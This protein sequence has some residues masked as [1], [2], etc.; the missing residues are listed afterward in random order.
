MHAAPSPPRPSK[1]SLESLPNEVL[2]EIFWFCKHAFRVPKKFSLL[3]ALSKVNR[4]FHQLVTPILGSTLHFRRPSQ[5]FAFLR[6][7]Y[8]AST[9]SSNLDTAKF[10]RHLSLGYPFLDSES[11][12]LDLKIVEHPSIFLFENLRTLEI[13]SWMMKNP[14]FTIFLSQHAPR[15]KELSMLVSIDRPFLNLA[16]LR[17]LDTLRITLIPTTRSIE[18]MTIAHDPKGLLRISNITTFCFHDRAGPRATFIFR[19]SVF[20][21]KDTKRDPQ[22]VFQFID[23]HPTLREVNVEYFHFCVDIR[24]EAVVKLAEGTGLWVEPKE[25]LAQRKERGIATP[26]DIYALKTRQ[27]VDPVAEVFLEELFIIEQPDDF[28]NISIDV[29]AFAFKRMLILPGSLQGGTFGPDQQNPRYKVEQLAINIPNH[30]FYDNGVLT[31]I[32]D[33][34]KLPEEFIARIEHLTVLSSTDAT[35]P[36]YSAQAMMKQIS[37]HLGNWKSLRVLSLAH[38]ALEEAWRLPRE[39]EISADEDACNIDDARRR[40]W[41][42]RLSGEVAQYITSL[43]QACPTLE[44][45]HIRV[46]TAGTEWFDG[47]VVRGDDAVWSWKI[48]RATG[49]TQ[50]RKHNVQVHGHLQWREYPTQSSP[51]LEILV[52]QELEYHHRVHLHD[53]P[54][55]HVVNNTK[56]DPCQIFQFIDLHPS[57]REV[58]VGFFT[59]LSVAIRLEAVFKLVEGTGLWADPTENLLER[60]RRGIVTSRDIY[61][62]EK[63]QKMDRVE[64]D[65]IQGLNIAEQP[66]DFPGVMVTVEAFA[67]T[68]TLA[69]P[70]LDPPFIP[71][72]QWTK[73]NVENPENEFQHP[74]F[75]A[76]ELALQIGDQCR[77]DNGRQT[78]IPDIFKLPAHFVAAIE[79]FTVISKTVHPSLDPE[80]GDEDTAPVQ[81]L[82]SVLDDICLY[83]PNWQNLRVLSIHADVLE[84]RDWRFSDPD[85]CLCDNAECQCYE[86]WFGDEQIA[87]IWA[88][89]HNT[90]MASYVA[91]LARAPGKYGTQDAFGIGRFFGIVDLPTVCKLEDY[92]ITEKRLAS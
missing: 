35:P 80:D 78:D 92:S 2:L 45:V 77:Y 60:K 79:K 90:E 44:E 40:L 20:N 32:P 11:L 10:V 87:S 23:L 69:L 26:R 38:P 31:D 76:K 14:D 43:A 9:L 84:N 12:G 37:M 24:L 21:T 46:I 4:R 63:K 39:E 49:E 7:T 36:A 50:M 65:F 13:R 8:D 81:S 61:A 64:V 89:K 22:D 15:L 41:R 34:F 57:L 5:Y 47:H 86:A 59:K 29:I 17:D 58:N 3:F 16:G 1:T 18:T 85:D 68:R 72:S 82:Q 91:A 25:N 88:K 28:P 54:M 70:L 52:G 67:F 51:E 27:R 30:S 56:R 6:D 71:A 48:V 83:L 55:R 19:T 42:D 75:R 66:D 73:I 62:H 53:S 74:R 33:I